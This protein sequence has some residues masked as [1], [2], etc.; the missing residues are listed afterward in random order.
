LKTGVNGETPTPIPLDDLLANLRGTDAE[1]FGELS[2]KQAQ[3]DF[4]RGGR[5]F[6][7]VFT[8][9]RIVREQG[10]IRLRNADLFLLER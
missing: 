10:T 6:R 5:S 8:R 3:I 9:L 4:E 7:V 1:R 2:T